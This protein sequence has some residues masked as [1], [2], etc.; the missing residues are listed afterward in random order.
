MLSKKVYKN[1]R[2]IK[3]CHSENHGIDKCVCL[4][5]EEPI[6]LNTIKALVSE[7]IVA[8]MQQETEKKKKGLFEC[9][10]CKAKFTLQGKEAKRN[11]KCKS[12]GKESCRLCLKNPHKGKC[13]ERVNTIKE[14]QKD[15][16][17]IK[18]CPY[19]LQLSS[20]QN[21]GDCAHVTCV[22]CKGVF[23]IC[24]GAK[25]TPMIAHGCHYHREGCDNFSHFSGEDV[26]KTDCEMC[27][28]LGKLCPRPKPLEDGDIPED[29]W[30]I[31]YREL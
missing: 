18:P 25:F 3:L 5:C 14:L 15:L 13:I 26:M 8:E 27:K 10:S 7:E 20:L 11:V 24:C 19:C 22:N 4:S 16:G 9:P 28:A 1:F 23:L 2:F 17:D 29:E 30:P 12:C 6:P 31:E 21:S